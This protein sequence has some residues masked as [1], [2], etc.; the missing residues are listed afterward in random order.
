M[1][2][3]LIVDDLVAIHEMLEAVVQPTGLTAGFATNGQQALAK[4]KAE[5]FDLVLT[6]VDMKPMDGM[7]LL[8][9]LRAFDPSAV[10]I[11]MTGY[12]SADSAIQALKLGAFDYIQKPFKVDE[13]LKTLRRALEF[14]EFAGAGTA[15]SEA[16]PAP[17]DQWEARLVG[18]SAA[19]A[20]LIQQLKKLVGSKSPV[21]LQG[22]PGT[23]KRM[24]AELLHAAGHST[25]APF[26]RVDCTQGGEADFVSELIGPQG[27]GGVRVA[28]AQGGTL[29]LDNISG[30]P[31]SVQKA[32][33]GV[34]R[35]TGQSLRLICSSAVDLEAAVDEG[36]F[37]D[38]LFYRLASLPVSLP[39]LRERREDIP[40][41]VRESAANATNPSFPAS[42]IEFTADAI[43]TLCAHFWPGNIPE[44]RQ[45][46]S[47][48]VA[49]T[50]S[51]VVSSR[52]LPMRLRELADWPSL[53]DYLAGQEREYIATVLSACKDDREV[54]ARVLKVD[55]SKLA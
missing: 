36:K 10:V 51:R 28:E 45:V 27:T 2:S 21:L 4:Y 46:V 1:P 53:A 42:Q 39:P 44:L 11:I 47:K 43:E 22:E 33:G 7:T 52:Q 48:I 24:V 23:G 20:R 6:D 37:D 18:R 54:A 25:D 12:A 26:V 13:L 41:L 32:L 17:E 50:D 29:F 55:P 16:A 31:R 30:L 19:S 49:S 34:L 5:P 8:K 3:I 35:A 15:P 14:K 9:E 40:A 38:Q